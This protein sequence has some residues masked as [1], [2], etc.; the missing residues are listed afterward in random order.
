MIVIGDGVPFTKDTIAASA[1]VNPPGGPA[2]RQKLK[3][4]YL[5]GGITVE[6][7]FTA[8]CEVAD[9]YGCWSP[10]FS[11][12]LLASEVASFLDL[13]PYNC[14]GDN[15]CQSVADQTGSKGVGYHLY[16]KALY[17]DGTEP[18]DSLSHPLGTDMSYQV[19]S[20][21]P[22]VPGMLGDHVLLRGLLDRVW[23]P[24]AEWKLL[25]QQ[26][27][28]HL[29]RLKSAS[30]MVSREFAFSGRYVPRWEGS[31]HP[32]YTWYSRHSAKTGAAS[33]V[34]IIERQYGPRID[35][36]LHAPRQRD[37]VPF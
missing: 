15:F 2:G 34:E 12:A 17:R 7:H 14:Q 3:S 26:A 32:G 33:F 6:E 19:D 36:V 24:P 21:M 23:F 5:D 37:R 9:H 4:G 27:L 16:K 25:Y 10:V 29:K 28:R 18:P 11:H 22:G 8:I 1:V 35:G 13:N 31:A 30:A 20:D